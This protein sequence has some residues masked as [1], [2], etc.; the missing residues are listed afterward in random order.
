MKYTHIKKVNGHPITSLEGPEGEY[1]YSSTHS[2]RRHHKTM[3]GQH[4]TLAALPP[5][6]TRYQLYRRLGRPQ[7]WSG[8]V[9]KILP[10]LG[11]DPQTVQPKASRYTD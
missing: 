8:C 9:Q 2:Q 10:P 11:F 4:H 7:R 5:V 1:R 6:K 3:G